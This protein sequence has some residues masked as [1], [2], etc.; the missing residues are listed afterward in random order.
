MKLERAND[1]AGQALLWMTQNE[2]AMLG[3]L[4]ATGANPDE[5]RGRAED[6]EFLGFVLDFLMSI[7]DQARVFVEET[8]ISADDLRTARM[9]LPGGADPH[10]T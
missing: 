10:W 5:L 3:F 9:V 6:P 2:E 1:I 8:Q 4:G 7:D